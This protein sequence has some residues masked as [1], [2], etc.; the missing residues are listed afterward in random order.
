MVCGRGHIELQCPKIL[1][2]VREKRLVYWTSTEPEGVKAMTEF[3]LF[4][5]GCKI[6]PLYGEG[7]SDIRG[8]A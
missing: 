5:D 1:A 8:L 3:S 7:K 6:L 2:L 4:T